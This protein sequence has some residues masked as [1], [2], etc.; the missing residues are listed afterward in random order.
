MN[1]SKEG[2]EFNTNVSVLNARKLL[3]TTIAYRDGELGI[4]LFS[5]LKTAMH[6]IF[7]VK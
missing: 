4:F 3:K 6:M 2:E 5:F 1:R 7:T